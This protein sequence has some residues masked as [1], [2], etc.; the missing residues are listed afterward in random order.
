MKAEEIL[1]KNYYY[2]TRYIRQDD[3]FPWLRDKG[4]FTRGDQEEVELKYIQTVMKA[5]T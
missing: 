5:S 2:L 1:K 4:V 3:F